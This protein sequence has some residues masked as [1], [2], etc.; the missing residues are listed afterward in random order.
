M[1]LPQ[2]PWLL[3]EEHEIVVR[4]LLRFGLI[5]YDNARQL[6]L[7]S[8]GKTDVYINLRDM[9]NNAEATNFLAELYAFALNRLDLDRFVEVPEAV[10]G[11]AGALSITTGLPYLTIREQE[12]TARATNARVIGQYAFGDRVAIVDDVITDGGSKIEPYRMCKQ[13]GLDVLGL[14]V[15]VDRQ[16]GWRQH[17]AN[18]GIQ[19]GVWPGMTLHDVRK[20][21]ISIGLMQRCTPEAEAANPLILALDNMSWEQALGLLDP[22]RTT[23]CIFKVNDLVFDEGIQRL[24]PNLSVYGRAMV[25]L[26]LHEI[27]NTVANTC[28]RLR[29]CPPWAVT[30]H[31]SGGGEMIEAA[32]KTLAGTPT[33]V[34]AIS[35]L[36]SIDKKTCDEVYHRLPLTQVRELLKVAFDAG[37]HGA[38]CSA[39]EVGEMF[40]EYPDKIFVVPGVRS[41]G[42][43]T[44]DQKR[45]GTPAQALF[46]GAKYIVGGRQF[47]EAAD[48]VAEVHR[49]LT[50][51]LN[52]TLL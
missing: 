26:K 23:G 35:V 17:L 2:T 7:K 8:G 6:P 9:R 25:D 38:V 48:P 49:V 41:P 51:E 30:V 11:L 36:T 43:D 31:A 50:E 32:I 18:S 20:Q 1:T 24:L 13:L 28:K 40:A 52:I 29:A 3:P 34:L 42:A 14:V 5:K 44:G 47:T 16:Q 39:H 4:E 21:L 15:L 46:D 37:A 33:M 45:V 12:K 19:T 22:L 10:S 27:P